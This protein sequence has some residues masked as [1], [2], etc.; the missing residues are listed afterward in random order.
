MQ[1]EFV[2]KENKNTPRTA[3]SF[4]YSLNEPE[5]IPGTYLL[6]ARLFTQGTIN[7]SAQEI[8]EELDRYAIE[9]TAEMKQDFLRF[10]FV[11]LNE[12]FHRAVEITEDIIKN[13][14]FADFEREKAKIKGE[15]VA[16]LDAPRMKALDSYYKNI[17][18]G[19]HYGN[20]HTK[21]LDSIDIITREDVEQ[22]YAGFTEN[23]RKA[24]V[25]TGDI[26]HNEAEFAV[27]DAF[28][29]IPSSKVSS[30]PAILPINGKKESVIEQAKLNQAHIIQGWLVPTFE[31]DDAPALMLLNNILGAGGL[32]SRLF[33]ELRDKK[34]LAYTVRSSYEQSADAANFSIYIGTEPN[35]IQIAIDGFGQ[36]LQKLK[37]IAV[38]EQEL[39]RKPI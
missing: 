16:E 7:R 33:L 10:K 19:H 24:I 12:D 4:N 30:R 17:F 5:K 26:S 23:S 11:C 22:A 14:T 2:Y 9:F 38:T 25:V 35:N 18:A 3:F 34:G 1:V 32:S 15:I 6:M 13:T 39:A 36:E 21:I 29:D 8:A 28:G 31:S 37:D 27:T 20:V